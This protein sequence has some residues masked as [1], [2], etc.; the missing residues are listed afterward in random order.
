MTQL[1]LINIAKNEIERISKQV[2]DQTNSKLME[3]LMVNEWKN[4][5]N[6]VNLFQKWK[7]KF[8]Q[9]FNVCRKGLLPLH[10]RS[11]INQRFR[12]CEATCDN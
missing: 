3:I 6:V 1:R 11:F 12:I 5:A 7:Q 8:T 10:Q 4:S 9:L 2:S